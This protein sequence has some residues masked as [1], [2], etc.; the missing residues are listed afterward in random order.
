MVDQ[1]APAQSDIKAEDNSVDKIEL[2]P[3]QSAESSG[4]G[5]GGGNESAT[6]AASDSRR[7]MGRRSGRFRKQPNQATPSQLQGPH[8]LPPPGPGLPPPGSG[9]T[10]ANLTRDIFAETVNRPSRRGSMTSLNQPKDTNDILP[11]ERDSE[12]DQAVSKGMSAPNQDQARGGPNNTA[13]NRND[14][15]KRAKGGSGGGGGNMR[16]YNSLPRLGKERQRGGG[17]GNVRTE[18]LYN[19]EFKSIKKQFN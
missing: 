7:V 14:S 1:E 13:T 11:P 18:V 10:A 6:S 4:G 12:Y 9:A 8:R 19:E 17:S 15:Y 3:D 5:G 2:A 16:N